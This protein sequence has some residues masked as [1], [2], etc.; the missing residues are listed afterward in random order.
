MAVVQISEPI[1]SV[2]RSVLINWKNFTMNG[3]NRFYKVDDELSYQAVGWYFKYLPCNVV[4]SG[5]GSKFN[6][7]SIG[8]L[9]G[10]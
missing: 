7:I 9:I 1:V 4:K 2:N 8:I 10:F 3:T 6:A 5:Y